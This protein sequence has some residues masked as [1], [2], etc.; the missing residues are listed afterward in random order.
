MCTDVG[1]LRPALQHLLQ[2]TVARN[3]FMLVDHAISLGAACT[4]ENPRVSHLWPFWAQ[5]ATLPHFEDVIFDH[6][7][8]IEAYKQPTRLRCF[9]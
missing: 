7:R 4:V 6:C 2:N 3:T 9:G 5:S 1:A 8:F